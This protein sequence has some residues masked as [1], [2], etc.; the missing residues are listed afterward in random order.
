MGS[1]IKPVSYT[2]LDGDGAFAEGLDGRQALV[3]LLNVL[4]DVGHLV[5]GVFAALGSGTVAGNALGFDFDFH[6]AAVPAIDL[7]AGRL[8]GDNHF[9]AQDVFLDDV[10]PAEAVA[11]FFL[12]AGDHP[13]GQVFGY[14]VQFLEHGD[15]D[16][17]GDETAFL[18]GDAA[19]IDFAIPDFGGIGLALGPQA[20]VCLLYTSRCV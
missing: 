20:D 12:H 16:D 11:V 7:Q 19:A 8:G 10:L 2:H 18:V 13:D 5:D 3:E 14:H 15:G 6:A 1:G 4:D 17:G 9:G